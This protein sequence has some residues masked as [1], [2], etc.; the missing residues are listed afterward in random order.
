M[1]DKQINFRASLAVKNDIEKSALECGVSV[2]Q[3][4]ALA[5]HVVKTMP[6]AQLHLTLLKQKREN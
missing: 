1:K 6:L 5:H 4:L 3:Y 2:S